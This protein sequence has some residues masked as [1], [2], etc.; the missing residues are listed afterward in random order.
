MAGGMHGRGHV[1]Q[2]HNLSIRHY[3]SAADAAHT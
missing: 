1:W 2:E 3:Y